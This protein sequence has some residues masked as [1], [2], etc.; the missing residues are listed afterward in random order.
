M[1]DNNQVIAV[2]GRCLESQSGED[3]VVVLSLVNQE[4][5]TLDGVGAFIWSRLTEGKKS[6][7]ELLDLVTGEF[8]VD[9]AAARTD[10][11]RFVEELTEAGL[12]ER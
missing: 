11:T 9:D 6:F 12:I 8:A 4:Y 3:A 10:L 7:A 1:I 2:S 5:Y